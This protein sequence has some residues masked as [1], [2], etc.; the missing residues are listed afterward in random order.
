[1]STALHKIYGLLDP[2]E[3]PMV[4]RYVGC[5]VQKLPNRLQSHIRE[6][7][8]SSMQTPRLVWLRQLAA[9]GLKPLIVLLEMVPLTDSWQEREK[10]WIDK[11]R[12]DALLNATT[13]GIGAQGLSQEIRDR[14][15]E[16]LRGRRL[17]EE[18]KAKLRKNAAENPYK[19]TDEAKRAI[20]ESK[21]GLKLGPLSDEAKQKLRDAI[22][23]LVWITNGRENRR[24]KADAIPAGW[25]KG[26][27]PKDQP[28]QTRRVLRDDL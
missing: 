10:F 28:K 12:T 24:V 21:K 1:M 15:S 23:S 19:H 3:S 9:D 17:S 2:R 26:R 20:S 18:H 22:G 11:C 5:S 14:I 7:E 25:Q 27:A 16:A 4:I 6:S 8:V 13:G